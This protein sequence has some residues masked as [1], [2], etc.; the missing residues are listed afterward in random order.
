[1]LANNATSAASAIAGNTFLRSL[2]GAGFPLFS[3]YMFNGMGIQWASTLLGCVAA[4]LI[5]IPVIFYLYGAK[6][7]QKSSF[8]PTPPPQAPPANANQNGAEKEEERVDHAAAAS[9]PKLQES[10]GKETA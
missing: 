8:A 2:C 6:I 7:R 4:V 3:T 10:N 9:A 1:V 5:P